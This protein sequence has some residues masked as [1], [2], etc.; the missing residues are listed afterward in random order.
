MYKKI[1]K[2]IDELF[3]LN[4]KEKEEFKIYI[5][6]NNIKINSDILD[7]KTFIKI[8]LKTLLLET[9][10]DLTYIE[11]YNKMKMKYLKQ[12]K[13]NQKNLIQKI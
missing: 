2:K 13:K 5:L 7:E 4:F 3:L 9:K 6:N 12:I 1:L 11:I 10:K 8:Y